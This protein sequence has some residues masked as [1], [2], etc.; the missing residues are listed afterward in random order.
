MLASSVAAP[1]LGVPLAGPGLSSPQP[2]TAWIARMGSCS[3]TF[4]LA[5]LLPAA[6]S[7]RDWP[8]KPATRSPNATGGASG[9]PPRFLPTKSSTAWLPCSP[10][11]VSNPNSPVGVKTCRFDCTPAR[12]GPSPAGIPRSCARCTWDC[13][14]G[15]WLSLEPQPRQLVC[16]PSSSHT[17]V[18]R[19]SPQPASQHLTRTSCAHPAWRTSLT[20]PIPDTARLP[21]SYGP[22][23]HLI[24][25]PLAV[26]KLA[27]PDPQA[28]AHGRCP[29]LRPAFPSIG[30]RAR[31]RR[32]WPTNGRCRC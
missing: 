22:R 1:T 9:Q 19:I 28:A 11:S 8:R 32:E 27:D 14:E 6:R 2:Q 25:S 16:D 7:P 17:C 31:P 21:V 20:G 18:W 26:T 29:P 13:S 23:N 4:S 12:S 15:R 24:Q 30:R 5:T 3:P 10:S